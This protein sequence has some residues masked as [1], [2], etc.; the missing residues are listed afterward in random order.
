MNWVLQE[1]EHH[2]GS[3][4]PYVARTTIQAGYLSAYFELG[5]D[6]EQGIIGVFDR[7]RRHLH[8]CEEISRRVIAQITEHSE[9]LRHSSLNTRNDEVFK[10]PSVRNL[11]NDL[12]TFLFHTKLAFRELKDLF[13]F[14]QDKKFKQTTRYVN[15]AN[16]SKKRFGEENQLTRWLYRN[17]DWIQKLMDSRNAVEHPENQSLVI[18][19]FHLT[20][21]GTISEP[22]WALNDEEPKSILSDLGVIPTNMLEFAEILLVYSLSNIRDI[23]P[24]VI[25]EI[26]EH[27]REG[28]R[29]VRFIATLEQELDEAG[30]YKRD[31]N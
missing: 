6:K 13:R 17:C 5:E 11:T 23:Y 24:V 19:N 14:T 16:W 7:F 3:A 4:D 20:E 10:L 8:Q 2:R 30:M 9:A 22:I 25:A 15:I 18:K 31:Q 21:K 29:P 12:E 1:E 27:K 28:A 26:P